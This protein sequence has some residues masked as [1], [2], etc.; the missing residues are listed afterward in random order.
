[1]LIPLGVALEARD[2]VTET[3]QGTQKRI[4][5]TVDELVA[6][7]GS[8][9]A[10]DRQLKR[11]ETRGGRARTQLE[12]EVRRTRRRLEREARHN[13]SRI[14]GQASSARRGFD[15]QRLDVLGQ[16][17]KRVEPVLGQVE[18]R[19][20]PVFSAVQNGVSAGIKLVGDAP[21]RLARVA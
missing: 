18:K 13:R 11:F 4:A 16:V 17:E 15:R 9:S 7:Y 12:R 20:D 3:A 10:V 8:V 6:K 2:R 14:E 21:G 19:V 1:V 5:D